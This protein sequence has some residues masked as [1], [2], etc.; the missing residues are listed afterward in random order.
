V[1]CSRVARLQLLVGLLRP[2]VQVRQLYKHYLPRSCPYRLH[3]A[4][5]Y[6]DELPL[7]DAFGD[8]HDVTVALGEPHAITHRDALWHGDVHAVRVRDRDG[9]GVTDRHWVAHGNR[10]G[11]GVQHE[12]AVDYD[13]V[14]R[15]SDAYAKPDAVPF[16]D[17]HADPIDNDFSFTDTI[18]DDDALCNKHAI[19]ND[20]TDANDNGDAV[21]NEH[22]VVDDIEE[23]H[24]LANG[25]GNSDAVHVLLP[26]AIFDDVEF[27]HAV[28]CAS[29]RLFFALG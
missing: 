3:E 17:G 13:D 6:A 24:A 11:H 4:N 15:V 29:R 23:W 27:A 10:H 21:C 20:V 7:G 28:A 16:K 12:D 2:Q 26:H 5:E 18:G 19:L 25:H 14:H 8:G 9:D 22:A 1:D